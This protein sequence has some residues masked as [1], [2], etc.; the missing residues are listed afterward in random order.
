MAMPKATIDKDGFLS[1]HEHDVRRAGQILSME[2]EA[3]THRV[4]HASDGA[5]WCCIPAPDS[6]HISGA[7]PSAKLVHLGSDIRMFT[8]ED[9]LPGLG[10]DQPLKMRAR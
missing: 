10:R 3:E 8:L 6:G 1:R 7:L 2:A 4:K 5:F 9:K